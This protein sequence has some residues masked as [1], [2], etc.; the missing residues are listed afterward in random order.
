VPDWTPLKNWAAFK[1]AWKGDT[2]AFSE[3]S[4]TYRARQEEKA[5]LRAEEALRRAQ[6]RGEE[7]RELEEAIEEARR[8]AY[9]EGLRDRLS[10]EER[11]AILD[12][13]VHEWVRKGFT[14][15]ARTPT[16]AQLIKRKVMTK[17][18]VVYLNADQNGNIDVVRRK[19]AGL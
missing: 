10:M 11:E 6:R 4:A 16:T 12:S 2:Q 17:N 15:Q 5:Q 14:L 1:A 8:R 13:E 9:E 3:A 19:V 18:R 7:A